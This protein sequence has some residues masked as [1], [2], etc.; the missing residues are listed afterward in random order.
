LLDVEGFSQ[1][2][3]S[4]LLSPIAVGSQASV[5]EGVSENAVVKA[6]L[7]LTSSKGDVTMRGEEGTQGSVEVSSAQFAVLQG[8][9]SLYRDED[10]AAVCY[11]DFFAMLLTE[12][13]RRGGLPPF[14]VLDEVARDHRLGID[15]EQRSALLSYAGYYPAKPIE[16]SGGVGGLLSA[17]VLKQ[18]SLGG[19]GVVNPP[20][21]VSVIKPPVRGERAA[22]VLPPVL[23]WPRFCHVYSHQ[24]TMLH[25]HDSGEGAVHRSE[26]SVRA[27]HVPRG[28]MNRAHLKVW[29]LSQ[30]S[31]SGAQGYASTARGRTNGAHHKV[32]PRPKSPGPEVDWSR[33]L[34][35]DD[36]TTMWSS[37][38]DEWV[39][40]GIGSRGG[41]RGQRRAR[42]DDDT[43]TSATSAIGRYDS[44]G[45]P[46]SPVLLSGGGSGPPFGEA[47]RAR[48][49]EE[50]EILLGGEVEEELRSADRGRLERYLKV[51][52]ERTRRKGEA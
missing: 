45:R 49:I 37:E 27:F 41:R 40:G 26:K 12:T 39:E 11:L 23:G 24:D 36:A 20:G 52:M 32:S 6:G 13:L 17:S 14:E 28:T 19:A 31:G 35:L 46:A 4:I 25:S 50:I 7:T 9:L 34:S 1:A 44:V 2:V 5:W 3:L 48:L 8:L 29:E 38:G 21:G 15:D 22:R 47:D 43:E 33:D 18:L 16:R 42:G 10:D 51:L 30:A